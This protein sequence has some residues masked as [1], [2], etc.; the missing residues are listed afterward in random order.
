[1]N[2]IFKPQLLS[3]INKLLKPFPSVKLDV[4][5]Q[6]LEAYRAQG[7]IWLAL[8]LSSRHSSIHQTLVVN[9]VLDPEHMCD[10]VSHRVHSSSS[11]TFYTSFVSGVFGSHSTEGEDSCT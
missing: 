11:P 2:F 7:M 9:A 4:L 5:L 10:F 3:R 6:L 1:M 8:T